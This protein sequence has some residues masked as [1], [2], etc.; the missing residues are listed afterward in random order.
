[1][2]HRKFLPNTK[3]LNQGSWW[4]VIPLTPNGWVALAYPCPLL[5]EGDG[6]TVWFGFAISYASFPACHGHLSTIHGQ[7]G[8][9]GWACG[10]M[11]LLT[12]L[13]LFFTR[14]NG[15]TGSVRNPCH[16]TAG[17][18][19]GRRRRSQQTHDGQEGENH[20][21]TLADREKLYQRPGSLHQGSNSAPEKH[22][23][24]C[25]GRRMRRRCRGLSSATFCLQTISMQAQVSAQEWHG[26][27][28]GSGAS[29]LGRDVSGLWW[30]AL[31]LRY[32][33]DHLCCICI[34]PASRNLSGG[35]LG[36]YIPAYGLQ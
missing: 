17:G 2:L 1:M 27:R 7:A 3:H 12:N 36:Y 32:A 13:F 11:T 15:S 23:G 10:I 25:R 6:M 20:R 4:W 26:A 5:E 30:G 33:P 28:S 19:R 14:K 24:E 8:Q 9:A 21:R 35:Q 31:K 22:A 16:P 34:K 18:Q 29:S